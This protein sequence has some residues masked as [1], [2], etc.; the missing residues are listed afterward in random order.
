MNKKIDSLIGQ[1][2]AEKNGMQWA[3]TSFMREAWGST[4]GEIAEAPIEE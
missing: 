3:L 1:K 2:A 4:K